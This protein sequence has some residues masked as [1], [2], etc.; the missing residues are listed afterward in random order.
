MGS[1]NDADLLAEI[2]RLRSDKERLEKALR[3]L[4]EVAE[5][6]EPWVDDLDAASGAMR[7]MLQLRIREARASLSSPPEKEKP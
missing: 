7:G 4:A 2:A 6:A 5:R 3:N 1:M